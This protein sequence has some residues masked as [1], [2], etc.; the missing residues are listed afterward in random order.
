M[1]AAGTGASGASAG[2]RRSKKLGFALW[3]NEPIHTTISHVELAEHVGLDS[4]WLVDTQLIC[5]EVYV[6]LAACAT[7]TSRIQLATG[8]TVPRTRHPSVMASTFATLNELS[9]GRMIVGLGTG[10]SALRTIGMPPARLAELEAYL[11]VLQPL[12]RNEPVRFEGGVEGKI[13]WLA[14]PS[15]IPIY[16]AATGPKVTRAAG[17]LADGVIMLQGIAPHLVARALRLI[18]EGATEAGRS[19][20]ALDV[21][22]WTYLGLASDSAT[23]RDHVRGRVAAALKISNAEWFDG[24]D[25]DVVRRLQREYDYF[26]H[27]SS[28]PAHAALVPDSLIDKYAIAGTPDEVRERLKDLM[29]QPGFGHVVLSP[30]VAG[31][32]S[33]PIDTVLRTLEKH[34]LPHL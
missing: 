4:V 7:R 26:K 28:N 23:A 3:G 34:I 16:L 25:A 6:T 1:S 15:R 29:A 20:E 19:T 18:G 11:A 24:E 27:A 33:F 22:C 13:T 14:A 21:V 10:N 32:G 8:V 2:S 12:L 30:Q 31:Q 17:R 5:R 9:R